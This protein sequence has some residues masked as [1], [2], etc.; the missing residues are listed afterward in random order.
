MGMEFRTQPG[1]APAEADFYN[2]F[3][4]LYEHP[5]LQGV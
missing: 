3:S 1:R 5:K 4:F 2:Q